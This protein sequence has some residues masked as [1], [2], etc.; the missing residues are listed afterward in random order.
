M[1]LIFIG[2]ILYV[3]ITVLGSV[4]LFNWFRKKTNEENRIQKRY[5]IISYTA[6]ILFIVSLLIVLVIYSISFLN[7]INPYIFFTFIIPVIALIIF[8]VFVILFRNE[9]LKNAKIVEEHNGEHV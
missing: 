5:F 9:L 4:L 1:L 6:W 2:P 7:S 3:V 8:V